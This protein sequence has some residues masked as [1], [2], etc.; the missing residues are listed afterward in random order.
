MI[1][2]KLHG[3]RAVPSDT[4]TSLDHQETQSSRKNQGTKFPIR[5]QTLHKTTL[6][7]MVDYHPDIVSKLVTVT[8]S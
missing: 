2:I 3:I 7:P 1:P 5:P 4:D 6:E 8:T